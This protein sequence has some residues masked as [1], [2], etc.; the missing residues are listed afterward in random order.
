MID[1][2]GEQ[3]P[4]ALVDEDG[5]LL[6]PEDTPQR[7]A[8]STFGSQHRDMRMRTSDV[9]RAMDVQRAYADPPPPAAIEVTGQ[10][11][12]EACFINNS[13]TCLGRC[14][15]AL[16]AGPKG[17]KPPFR[18]TKLTRLLSGAFGGRANTALCVCVGNVNCADAPPS[19]E[20][21]S[22]LS[23]Y[24]CALPATIAALS[25]CCT[26]SRPTWPDTASL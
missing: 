19:R 6:M 20:P 9:E 2:D 15:Q 4:L 26:L 7:A 1:V 16:A 23:T 22:G 5:K 8:G 10:A 13:L 12:E 24:S 3:E 21:T 25:S 17:G 14:V 18:E 11:F